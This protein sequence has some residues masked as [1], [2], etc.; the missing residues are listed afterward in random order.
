MAPDQLPPGARLADW[1][2]E[3]QLGE[4]GMAVV[5][6]AHFDRLDR[7]DVLKV[8]RP[9]LAA[10]PAFRRRFRAEAQLMC[11]WRHP[12]VVTVYDHREQDGLLFIAMQYVA[13]GDLRH[14]LRAEGRLPL[15]R[16]L[17]VAG[18][19]A[20]ALDSGHERGLV[21]RDVKPDNVLLQRWAPGREHVLLSDFGI[22]RSSAAESHLTQTGQLLL[23]PAYA[24][25]EQWSGEQI[26]GR[27]DQYALACLF[28]EMLTG[29]PPFSAPDP[30]SLARAHLIEP[31][32]PLPAELGLPA[33]V[34]HAISR[35]LAKDRGARFP[36]C[37]AFVQALEA[38]ASGTGPMQT[39]RTDGTLPDTG[40]GRDRSRSRNLLVAGAVAIAVLAAAGIGALAL[41]G[42]DEPTA[43]AVMEPST[44]ASTAGPVASPSRDASSAAPSSTDSA[45]ARQLADR[46]RA[47]ARNCVELP[48]AASDVEAT[49]RCEAIDPGV[50]LLTIT[51]Y[52]DEAAAR[53]V[54]DDTITEQRLREGA[55]NSASPA[56]QRW[57]YADSDTDQGR[58]T[59]SIDNRRRALLQW[60]IDADRIVLTAVRDD[61]DLRL[62]N[63]W[64]S[65]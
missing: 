57:S 43:S 61:G 64:W 59:C 29:R 20:D 30:T 50:D 46:F 25:P 38:A 18:Q 51:Q 45:A 28:Y 2:I 60:T 33:G 21:H 42:G 16:A 12:H 23:S 3:R 15:T 7:L 65:S 27:A 24:A 35:A 32:P 14:V 9:W 17:R 54:I 48:A 36:S 62:A 37:S 4:G 11:D 55:C 52:R 26:D 8:M 41:S 34:Q 31:P 63:L 10:D 6:L 13:E 1:T 44:G 49:V 39:R 56:W 5:Y 40:R 47:T 58:F 53:A 22:S 19:L